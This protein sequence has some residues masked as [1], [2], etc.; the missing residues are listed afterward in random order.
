MTGCAV[1]S[2]ASLFANNSSK[3]DRWLGSTPTCGGDAFRNELIVGHRFG[4]S[5]L[6]LA[7]EGLLLGASLYIRA[8]GYLNQPTLDGAQDSM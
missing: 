2:C 1:I 8:K 7:S 6:N 4:S 5:G 3:S